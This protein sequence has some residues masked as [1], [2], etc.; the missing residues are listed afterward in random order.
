VIGTIDNAPSRRSPAELNPPGEGAVTVVDRILLS[1]IECY[2]YGGVSDAEKEIG[3]RYRIDLELSVDT[4]RA[5]S[6]D[7][8]EDAVHYGLVHDAVVASLRSRSFNLLESAA[9]RIARN[10]LERFAV[11]CVMVRLSKLLPPI[12]GMVAS[13]AVEITRERSK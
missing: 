8:I 7:S 10:V 1:G 12:D 6:S 2:A 11:D 13:A 9:D 3:Q 5:G 4:R